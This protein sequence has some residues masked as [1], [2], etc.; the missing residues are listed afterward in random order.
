MYLNISGV[1]CGPDAGSNHA[2][3][4]ECYYYQHFDRYRIG[5]RL[6][7]YTILPAA[8]LVVLQFTPAIRQRLRLLHRING[9]IVVL[10][11]VIA[12]IGA[13]MIAREAFGGTLATQSWIG[14]SFILTT[15][16]LGIA[17]YNVKMLQIDQHRAWMLRTWFY[18]S[19]IITLR[20]IMI[21]SA[22]IVSAA[23]DFWSVQKCVK[24]FDVIGDA[25]QLVENYPSCASFI[26]SNN[27]QAV[28]AVKADFGGSVEQL[29]SA[30][31]ITF[32]MA[33]WLALGLHAIGV[34]VY[35]HLTPRESERLRQVSYERQVEA[36]FK[37]AGHA[38]LIARHSDVG[39]DDYSNAKT[40]GDIV[41][42]DN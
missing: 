7:L 37:N 38:G 16:G 30:M 13:I 1:F 3:P 22:Q 26:D 4:G 28:T 41:P 39:A 2:A 31:N 21:I 6:H 8:L 25:Q 14:A 11:A 24:L 29:M 9:Y 42:S 35:L 5:I 23:G 20:I 34:E 33:G 17:I 12:N 15:V 18:F 36:G 19:S 32:G 10:L 27:L 40:R